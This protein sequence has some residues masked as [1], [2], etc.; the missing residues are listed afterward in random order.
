MAYLIVSYCFSDAI[1]CSNSDD[2]SNTTSNTNNQAPNSQEASNYAEI[3]ENRI[4]SRMAAL[5]E[6]ERRISRLDYS[7][8]DVDEQE[9]LHEEYLNVNDDL[10]ENL[11]KLRDLRSEQLRQQINSAQENNANGN[12]APTVNGNSAHSANGNGNDSSTNSSR[13]GNS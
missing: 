12:N 13:N 4:E 7:A 11:Q 3:L 1:Y 9:R 10:E 6:I 2:N 5:N 8:Y